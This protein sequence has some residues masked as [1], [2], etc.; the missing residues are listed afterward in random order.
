M[1]LIIVRHGD[2]DYDIDSLTEIGWEEAKLA[3]EK[4]SKMNIRDFFVSPLGRLRI[5]LHV[6]YRK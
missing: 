5:L 1:R 4:L 6:R 2:P 3:A